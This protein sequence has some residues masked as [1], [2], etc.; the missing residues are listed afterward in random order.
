MKSST[1]GCCCR[2]LAAADW[3][4]SFLSLCQLV[5]WAKWRQCCPDQEWAK[6]TIIRSV[7]GLF[8]WGYGQRNLPGVLYPS[9]RWERPWHCRTPETTVT[10]FA[11]RNSYRAGKQREIPPYNKLIWTWPVS[12]CCWHLAA[13]SLCP[14]FPHSKS[15]SPSNKEIPTPVGHWQGALNCHRVACPLWAGRTRQLRAVHTFM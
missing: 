10:A 13:N 8:S 2:K 11:F 4:V 7:P 15:A 14:F 3:A 5:G 12:G 1:R 6:L 9:C